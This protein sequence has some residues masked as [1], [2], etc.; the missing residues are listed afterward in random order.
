MP[1]ARQG[2]VVSA[3]WVGLLSALAFVTLPGFF[4]LWIACVLVLAA[5]LLAICFA[6]GEPPR[7][8]WG[9]KETRPIRP[10]ADRLAELDDLRRRQLISDSEHTALRQKML[11]NHGMCGE[12]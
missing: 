11:K 1:C 10:L 7:W 3:V 6:K 2:W 4:G 5:A 9:G 12:V 8:R